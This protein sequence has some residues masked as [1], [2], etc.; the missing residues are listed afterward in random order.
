MTQEQVM[1]VFEK[2]CAN[3]GFD[4][5]KD[6][7]SQNGTIYASYE[8]GIMFGMFS[9]GFEASKEYFGLKE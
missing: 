2:T 4:F 9:I 6:D 5:T 1:D 8:T 7:S 3:W